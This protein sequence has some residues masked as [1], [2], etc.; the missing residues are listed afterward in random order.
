MT[1]VAPVETPSLTTEAEELL[2]PPYA[3]ILY[4]DDVNTMQHVVE[5]L[6]A[7]VPQLTHEEAAEIMLEAH[8]NGQARV[9]VAPHAEAARHRNC[10]ES[11][12]LTA[13]IEPA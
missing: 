11:R 2:E 7:C 6:L 1:T 10:L 8:T 9:T 13:T 4:N 12:G 3:V 5:S